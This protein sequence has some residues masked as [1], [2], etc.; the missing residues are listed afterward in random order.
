MK[1][2]GKS[3]TK[4]SILKLSIIVLLIS[5][6]PV[7]AVLYG[8][9]NTK[10]SDV[11]VERTIQQA[12]LN[13]NHSLGNSI[14]DNIKNG[15]QNAINEHNVSTK[16]ADGAELSAD[17]L[18]LLEYYQSDEFYAQLDQVF[19]GNDYL[20]VIEFL[21]APIND[22]LSKNGDESTAS[23]L[24]RDWFAGVE[25][26]RTECQMFYENIFGDLINFGESA[27]DIYEL[28]RDIW[29]IIELHPT[30]LYYASSVVS[31]IM[32]VLTGILAAIPVIGWIALGLL[33]AV[34]IDICEAMFY[35]GYIGRGFKVGVQVK[36]GWLGIPVGLEWIC[37]WI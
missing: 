2:K 17:E 21:F 1:A 14:K 37:T 8:V 13:I 26:S 28:A 6:I 7:S 33:I 5:I 19:S 11:A 22:I 24:L 35:A 27:W 30:V 29:E 4:S 36:T 3:F 10:Y 32:G 31:G 25:R 34:E 18:Y 20:G 15:I 16:S 23:G 12:E 9:V